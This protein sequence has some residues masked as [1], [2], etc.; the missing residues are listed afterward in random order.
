MSDS[1]VIRFSDFLKTSRINPGIKKGCFVDTSILFA[2]SYPPDQF[3]TESEELLE[4]FSE[5]KV[6][7]YTNLNVRSEFLDLHRRVMIPEGLSDLFHLYGTNLDKPLYTKIQSIVTA[8]YKA[9]KNGTTYKFNEQQV[10]SWRKILSSQVRNGQDGWTQFCSDF[11]FDNLTAVWSDTCEML[12]VNFLSKSDDHADWLLNDLNWSDMEKIVGLY[13]V[14]SFDAMIINL[15][16]NSNFSIMV[17]ADRD[18][19]YVIR[20]MTPKNKFVCVPDNLDL[21]E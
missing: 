12:G 18:L 3:N 9:Q 14:G 17:T 13:G 20:K 16:L 2:A 5:L 8:F 1:V 10:K 4:F 6:P 21:S 19:T 15:F 11:L 7:I